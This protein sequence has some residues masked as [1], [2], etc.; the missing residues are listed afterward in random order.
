MFKSWLPSIGA[1]LLALAVAISGAG[2]NGFFG[3]SNRAVAQE[4]QQNFP[5]VPQDYWAR[6]FIQALAQRGIIAGYPDGSYRPEKPVERE[7]FAAM[8]SQAFNRDRIRD[9]ASGSAFND[10]PNGY[11]AASPIEEAYESGLMSAY[12]GNLFLPQQEIPRVEALVSLANNLNLNYQNPASTTSQATTNQPETNRQNQ[13]P[14]I[15]NRLMFP[16]ASASLMQPIL[17]SLF[18]AKKPNPV[19]NR[20]SSTTA[21]TQDRT[22]SLSA[23][24]FVNSY[25]TD[26]DK[27]PQDAID[28]VA[29]ATQANMVVSYPEPRVLNPNELLKRSTA[30]ALIHQALVRQGNL[31]PLPNNV[32]ATKYL[33]GSTT[34]GDR[35]AQAAQ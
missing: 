29:A 2:A 31:E 10:V 25:Y 19:A 6:P 11:W 1:A 24:E 32:E 17:P 13:R 34:E 30:A 18:V 20:S 26:A 22:S 4:N 9:I 28:D 27:I 3:R 5:D 33:P 16:L 14:A 12:S 15:R 7:E 35:T 8:L 23:R 21:Q